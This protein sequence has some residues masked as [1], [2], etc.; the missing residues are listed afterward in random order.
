MEKQSSIPLMPFLDTKVCNLLKNKQEKP[1]KEWRKWAVKT[2]FTCGDADVAAA[3]VDGDRAEEMADESASMVVVGGR[4][5]RLG[6]G[7]YWL[8]F[9]PFLITMPFVFSE[10]GTPLML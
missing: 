7:Y 10:A 2:V 3:V 1:G 4:L 9:S 8:T 6:N 5:V